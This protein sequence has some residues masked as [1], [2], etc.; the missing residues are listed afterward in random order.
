LTPLPRP[1]VSGAVEPSRQHCADDRAQVVRHDLDPQARVPAEHPR[2]RLADRHPGRVGAGAD[3]QLA[4][5]EAAHR[6]DLALE[7]R[8][9]VEQRLS[10][11]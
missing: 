11:R 9:A 6:P 10:A 4:D 5:L 8:G 2:H 7:A 3:A 1:A